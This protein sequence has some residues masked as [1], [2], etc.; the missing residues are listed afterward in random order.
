MDTDTSGAQSPPTQGSSTG[1]QKLLGFCASHKPQIIRVFQIWYIIWATFLISAAY[2]TITQHPLLKTVIR[3]ALLSGKITLWLFV[4]VTLPGVLGRFRVRHPLITIGIMFRRHLGITTFLLATLHGLTLFYI[5]ALAFGDS[6][7]SQERFQ[8]FG[9]LTLFC[10]TAL[11]ATSNDWS[12]RKLGPNWKRLHKLV[13]IMFWLIFL[14]VG[15]QGRRQWML[16]IGTAGTL[17]ILSLLFDAIRKRVP[18]AGSSFATP[19]PIQTDVQSIKG[20]RI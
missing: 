6:L 5:P 13:Y 20:D 3:L 15:F 4:V 10:L 2:I 8:F 7:L 12:V 19:A 14:H 17:E 9:S 1:F 16:V 18:V 11:A